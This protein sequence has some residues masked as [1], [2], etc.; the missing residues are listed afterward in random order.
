MSDDEPKRHDPLE[1]ALRQLTPLPATFDRDRLL[2]RA[3]Q[4]SGRR[5]RWPLALLAAVVGA[6]TGIAGSYFGMPK[7]EAPP[8]IVVVRVPVPVAPAPVDPVEKP[9]TPAH[10][11]P[12]AERPTPFGE[13]TLFHLVTPAGGYLHM[14]DQALLRGIEA[15]P[16][17]VPTAPGGGQ[18]P[19]STNVLEMHAEWLGK[20]SDL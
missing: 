20:A 11:V 2:F 10:S 17:R 12:P 4:A 3:G 15:L 18:A 19:R 5:A 9:E 7:A 16:M 13:S 1:A 8:Q 14:R 6:G